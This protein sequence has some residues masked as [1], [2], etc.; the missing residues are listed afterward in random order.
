VNLN[1]K[2]PC[3]NCPFLIDGA[4]EL[5]PGRLE[6]IIED[7]VND[8][9]SNFQ[10]HKTVHSKHGGDWIEGDGGG[11]H[12]EPSGN[13]SMCIGSAIY[14]LKIGRPSISMRFALITKMIDLAELTAQ[15]DKI[16]EPMVQISV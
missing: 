12:Y 7:L 16:I 6:G 14:M 2:K 13:E 9:G 3:A 15:N 11:Q 4:I 5:A 10:C 1:L 8:D